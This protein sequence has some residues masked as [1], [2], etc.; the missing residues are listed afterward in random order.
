MFHIRPVQEF[1]LISHGFVVYAAL[2]FMLLGGAIGLPIPED[3]P[4][5]LAGIVAQL[6]RA[7]L[8]IL[9][10]VCY[11]GILIGDGLIFFAGRKLGPSVFSSKWFSKRFSPARIRL[12]RNAL[13]RRSLLTIFLARHLFYMRSLTFLICGAVRMK[14]RKFFTADALA[15]LVSTPIM[16]A[17]GY[18]AAEHYEAFL[19]NIRSAILI[20]LAIL[21]VTY[22]FR[23]KY[24]KGKETNG[25][26][27]S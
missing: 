16:M 18:F 12:A 17:I 13:E 2:F 24:S 14:V 19:H 7:D 27:H 25:A 26:G 8:L 5:I 15:A 10:V 21:L 6:G 11:C 4:L 22:L 20:L 3:V 23:R 1:I 9:F